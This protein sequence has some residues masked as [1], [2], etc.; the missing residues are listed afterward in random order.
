MDEDLTDASAEAG[1]DAIE[2]AVAADL[3]HADAVEK[4][5]MAVALEA[6]A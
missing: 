5:E 4:A 6:A 2:E 1:A 3:L